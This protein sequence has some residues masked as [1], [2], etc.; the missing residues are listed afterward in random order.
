MSVSILDI[1]YYTIQ[2]LVNT[3]CLPS[4]YSK[5]PIR[6][7]TIIMH[8]IFF[9]AVSF[10]IYWY[11]KHHRFNTV[12]HKIYAVIRLLYAIGLSI[13]LAAVTIVLISSKTSNHESNTNKEFVGFL[14]FY[15]F[16][17]LLSLYNIYLSLYYIKLALM[18][19]VKSK[20]VVQNLL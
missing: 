20:R 9:Y 7:L 17:I 10:S 1:I 12:W 2:V 6:F 18:K 15:V 8:L 13:Y 19:S 4:N 5:N 3:S 14:L 16:L 11:D